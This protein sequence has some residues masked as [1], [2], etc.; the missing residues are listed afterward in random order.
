MNNRAQQSPQNDIQVDTAAQSNSVITLK[1]SFIDISLISPIISK[2]KKIFEKTKQLNCQEVWRQL[3]DSNDSLSLT[4]DDSLWSKVKK[5]FSSDLSNS[6]IK[7]LSSYICQT[8][9][10]EVEREYFIY[11]LFSAA[12]QQKFFLDQTLVG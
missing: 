1:R 3:I 11:H 9:S 7:F 4:I 10:F 12:S 2:I 6:L 8:G 5:R